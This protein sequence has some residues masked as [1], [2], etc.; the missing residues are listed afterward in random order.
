MVF[1]DHIVAAWRAP[2]MPFFFKPEYKGS[3]NPVKRM[4][5]DAAGRRIGGKGASSTNRGVRP[6]GSKIISKAAGPTAF[7]GDKLFFYHADEVGKT[8]DI[9]II[10]RWRVAKKCLS[11]GNGKIIHGF[12]IHTSTVGEMEKEGGD[13]FLNHCLASFWNKRN[14]NNQ[15]M[16]GLVTLFIPATEGLDGFVDEYG[17]S[18]IENPTT[19]VYDKIGNLIEQG[20]REYIL[21]D[22]QAYIDAEDDIGLAESMRQTPLSF[23]ECFRGRAKDSG[24]NIQKLDD[25]ITE[26]KMGKRNVRVGYF[27]E[28]PATGKV[29]FIDDDFK[30]KFEMSYE[31]PDNR[32]DARYY[33]KQHESWFPM[34]DREFIAGGDPFKF[35][36]TKGRRKSNGGGA[37]FMKFNQQIDGNKEM[38]DWQTHRFVCTYDHRP[39]DQERV[40]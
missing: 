15:T 39:T 3:E 9:D 16:S 4:V 29:E 20:S 33:S 7:D 26:L 40:L 31:L 25:R 28:N 19:P 24:F 37:V 35:N 21:N 6:L 5:F 32:V 10:K 11:Q 38:E 14:K 22:R 12:S 8:K 17:N 34:N 27:Q 36:K 2:S 30:P 18:I 23:R 1:Q 13:Q